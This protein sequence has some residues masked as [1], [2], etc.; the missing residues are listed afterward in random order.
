MARIADRAFGA[1]LRGRVVVALLV[2]AAS[3]AGLVALRWL[4]IPIPY[5][6][7]LALLATF[8]ELVPLVGRWLAVL[9]A[10]LLSLTHSWTAAGA[11]LVIFVGVQVLAD[12]FLAPR[13]EQRH[14]DF[15]PAILALVIVLASQFGVIGLVAAAPIA[16]VARD[17][18]RYVYGRLA[19]PPRPAGLLPGEPARI[20]GRRRLA[21]APAR[22]PADGGA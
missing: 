2:G 5:P 20:A 15:H 1:A 10:V 3:F 22:P 19:E 18:F 13:L 6:L 17:W 8:G 4:G 9:P 12:A 16:L 21:P 11:V 14:V 7:L